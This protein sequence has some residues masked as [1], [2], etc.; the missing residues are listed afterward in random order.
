VIGSHRGLLMTGC[1]LHAWF[2]VVFKDWEDVMIGNMPF[3]HAYGLACLAGALVGGNPL[4]LVPDPRD[5]IDL[6]DTIHRHQAALLPGVPSLFIALCKQPRVQSGQADLHSL[7]LCVCGAAPLM[8][9]TKTRFENLTGGKLVDCYSLTEA[10]VAAIITPVL[11]EYKPGSVGV[12]LP[13]IEVRI[14]EVESGTGTLPAGQ[15]GEILMRAPN[16]MQGYWQRPQETAEAI[17]DGW[18][19]TGDLGYLDED[20]YL[21]IVDRKKDLIKPGGKQVWPREVEEVLATHPDVDEVGVAGVPDERFG[22]LVK[23]W[24]VLKPGRQVTP[25][26]LRAYC[27]ESLAPYK[28]PKEFEFR[29]NLPKSGVGKVLRRELVR[30]DQEK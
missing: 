13:D 7:K 8:Q 22:E 20:G 14:T 6:L 21:F 15:V 1:Q 19:F 12:P 26:E 24:V 23:A 3:F 29:D 17:R 18:L 4:A 10:L 9:E 5:M 16:L 2:S 25:G 11:G 30:Q 27:K 28:I